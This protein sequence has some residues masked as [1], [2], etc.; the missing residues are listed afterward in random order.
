MV[1]RPK[2]VP[3]WAN[4]FKGQSRVQGYNRPRETVSDLLRHQSKYFYAEG[5]RKI[6]YRW[7][8]CVTLLRDY[9][10]E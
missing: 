5:I 7:E 2:N 1:F 10:E 6:L 3:K 8:K 4:L 9:V